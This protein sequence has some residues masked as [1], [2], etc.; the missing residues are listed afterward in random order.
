MRKVDSDKIQSFHT[1]A[2][3]RILNIK[4]YDKVSNAAVRQQPDLPSLI[5]DRRHSLFGHVCRPRTHLPRSHCNCQLMLTLAFL[6]C[7]LETTTGSSK[8]NVAAT[9]RRGLRDI[10]WSRSDHKPRSLLVEIATTL[11]WS[12]AAVSVWVSA[13]V[14]SAIPLVT[15]PQRRKQLSTYQYYLTRCWNTLYQYGNDTEL[16]DDHLQTQTTLTTVTDSITLYN[17]M[18]VS[19]KILLYNIIQIY[20][21]HL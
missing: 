10:C 13:T 11:S 2:L 16:W 18:F 15:R 4:W 14:I 19:C 21:F 17:T 8:E 5:A 6:S 20:K 9:S 1:Q 7:R 3:S 12:S